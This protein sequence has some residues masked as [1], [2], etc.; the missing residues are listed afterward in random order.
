MSEIFSLQ[1]K[2]IWVFGGAGYL[3]QPTVTLLQ[4]MGARVLCID[5]EDRA[6]AFV[7]SASL[8]AK[9][10]PASLDVRD[11]AATKQFIAQQLTS[12]GV[13]HGLVNLTFTSTSRKLE[14]L[15]AADIDHANHSNVTATLLIARDIGTA[16]AKEKRGSM[17]LFSSIYGS[18]YLPTW[19]FTKNL[20]SRTP[21]SMES[22]K[23]V[24]Y[25]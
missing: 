16:M 3:G 2:D 6:A 4:A 24:S 1:G 10:T 11:G 18:V 21:L 13:P 17:V 12:R 7:Q 8:G 15:E 9:V 23:P 5:L 22:V 25:R 19:I 20:W 14:D